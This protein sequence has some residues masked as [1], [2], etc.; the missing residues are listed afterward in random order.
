MKNY[1][2]RNF[3][4]MGFPLFTF[5]RFIRHKEDSILHF[6]S[7]K[8]IAL[9]VM[10]SIL[11]TIW[12]SRIDCTKDLYMGSLLL[13]FALFVVSL[14][15]KDKTFTPAMTSVFGTSANVYL[16][17]IMVGEVLAITPLENMQFYLYIR[18]VVIFVLSVFVSLMIKSL[19]V[20]IKRNMP[21]R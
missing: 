18:P 11:D 21:G 7:S 4:F 3:L 16:F 20:C 15:T 14:K 9:L 19:A 5:G 10:L 2:L 6:V 8:H 1:M 17:H 12:V 13:A